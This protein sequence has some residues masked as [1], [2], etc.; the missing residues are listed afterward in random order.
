MNSFPRAS[1]LALG[2]DVDAVDTFLDQ[3]RTAYDNEAAALLL[4]S[5]SIRQMSF[6]MSRGGY[7]IAPIDSAL[8]RLE[9]AMAERE[10]ERAIE[11]E[12][13]EGY[14]KRV[15]ESSNEVLA[16]LSRPRRKRF[17]RAPLLTV[18]YRMSD[19]DEFAQHIVSYLESGSALSVDRVR[20][21]TFRAQR[22]GYDEKQ[23]DF[24]LDAVIDVVLASGRR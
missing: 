23:V 4:T 6:P 1:R 21:A 18:G 17:R 12:G 14:T 9:V 7:E 16:R 11:K 20:N 8:E 2:Y 13:W 22:G 24:V 10:R 15:L 19:V 3:A 5:R